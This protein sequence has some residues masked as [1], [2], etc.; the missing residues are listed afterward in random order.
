MALMVKDQRALVLLHGVGTG[1]PE[2]DWMARL[3]AML[4][5]LEYPGL[6]SAKIIAPK[7]AHALKGFDQ[8]EKRPPVVV[9][10]PA[11]D[12]ARRNR[13]EFE[14][15]TA[16]VEYRLGGPVGDR[17]EGDHDHRRYSRR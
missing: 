12:V 10:A 5:G 2:A 7:Y 11:G 4:K 14:R 8:P 15:R 1:A 9:K 13:R 17:S 3:S 6:P 16:A